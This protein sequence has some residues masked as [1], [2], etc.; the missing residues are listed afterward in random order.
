MSE[1]IC[2]CEMIPQQETCSL[3]HPWR[4]CVCYLA[5][6]P[7]SNYAH[8][9]LSA[10]ICFHLPLWAGWILREANETRSPRTPFS[11]ICHGSFAHKFYL[12]FSV[13]DRSFLK[14]PKKLSSFGH[15]VRKVRLVNTVSASFNTTVLPDQW[16]KGL[17]EI[18]RFIHCSVKKLPNHS[19][20]TIRK[21]WSKSYVFQNKPKL[22]A[23]VPIKEGLSTSVLGHLSGSLPQDP[24]L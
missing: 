2:N 9:S 5:S 12:Y 1:C 17:S 20:A 15:D 19:R 23:N 8:L 13:T 24:K 21:I 4:S 14:R 10:S 18:N 7:K 3:K 22:C 16:P 11:Q 6:I